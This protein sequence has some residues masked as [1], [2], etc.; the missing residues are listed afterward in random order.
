MK[1]FVLLL[2]LIILSSLGSSYDYYVSLDQ[3]GDKVLVSHFAQLNNNSSFNIALPAGY[4]G[5][6]SSNEYNLDDNL[7]INGQKISFSYY[8][9]LIN[10][11]NNQFVSF[12]VDSISQ[13]RL[14]LDFFTDR[15][16]NKEFT[17]PKSYN[18]IRKQEESI[19]SWIIDG[20]QNQ[21]FLISVSKPVSSGF[22]YLILLFLIIL[23]VLVL[24]YLFLFRR[25]K[26]DFL[27]DA[28]KKVIDLLKRADRHEMWQRKI[29]E[30]T[31]FS[32]AKLSRLVRNLE[33]RGLIEKIPM[34]NTNKVKLK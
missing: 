3:Q 13:D 25:R 26:N 9:D 14:F 10:E 20:N 4:Y 21:D 1:Q 17:F 22:N 31:G 24:I 16:L 8:L 2:S 33:S 23:V 34:G 19:V 7:T 6:K 5:F 32:K 29:Q 15:E 12:S 11:A 28:E 30:E 27:L 18:L